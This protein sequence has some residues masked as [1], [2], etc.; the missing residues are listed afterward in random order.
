MSHT[1]SDGSGRQP[2][3]RRPVGDRSAVFSPM[4]Q[5][6]TLS[7]RCLLK[8]TAIGTLGAAF[9]FTPSV[10]FARPSASQSTLDALAS[11]QEQLDQVQGQL[12]QLG[13]EYEA[14]AEKLSAT[15]DQ[16][17]EV[18]G[19]ISE[20][21]AT[22]AQ[23]EEELAAKK[24]VLARRVNASYKAGDSNLL[25]VLLAS[26][27]FDELTSNI[28]YMNKV[29][30]NDVSLIDSVTQAKEALARTKAELE[31]RKSQ[32]E[33]LKAQ[34]GDDLAA[35]QAKQQEAQQLL[36]S[37]SGEV[38]DLMA[39]RDAEI[40]ASAEEEKAEREKARAAAA[41]A[42]SRPA[43]SGS[44]GTTPNAAGSASG[45]GAAIVAACSR[46]GSPGGGL[47]AMWVSQVYQ[48]AGCGYPG[49]NAVDQYYAYCSSSDRS[50]LQPG[51]LIAVP[52]HP[53]TAA[54]RIYGHVGIY[55]GGGLVM[56]NVGYIRTISLDSWI[57][58]YE[59]G[60]VRARWGFA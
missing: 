12:D 10:A 37:L 41:A 39:Q 17:E 11:A 51:M 19:Q 53:H 55:I 20:T 46:V 22:I 60:G 4:N 58:Y 30:Q 42:A 23:K 21:E 45:K 3:Y 48:A 33:E 52:S 16:I 8:A 50:T 35:A 59:S 6:S 24:E 54:G 28:Y 18:N 9:A 15:M 56:D 32:L 34:Q 25:E 2:L 1:L 27:S 44:S 49:G 36:D 43:A 57:S 5:N 47:C 40:L 7:R 31:S 38:R 26:S 29:T 13:E 14:I